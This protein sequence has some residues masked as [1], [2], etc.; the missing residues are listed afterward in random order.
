MM[1]RKMKIKIKSYDNGNGGKKQTNY[2]NPCNYCCLTVVDIVMT[3]SN[4]NKDVQV[5][6]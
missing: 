3:N 6:L 4:N 5:V 2:D 1:T